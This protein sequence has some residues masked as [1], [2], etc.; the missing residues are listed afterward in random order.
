MN[1]IPVVFVTTPVKD[2]MVSL[3]INLIEPKAYAKLRQLASA[4]DLAFSMTLDQEVR[5]HFQLQ[6]LGET[7]A[8]FTS[9]SRNTDN[10][11]E[12]RNHIQ[13]AMNSVTY[14]ETVLAYVRGASETKNIMGEDSLYSLGVANGVLIVGVEHGFFKCLEN[15]VSVKKFYRN[16]LELCQSTIPAADL[17]QSD[18]F[19]KFVKLSISF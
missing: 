19:S 16:C 7:P 2:A 6:E 8:L 4:S 17:H 9:L 11:D 1:S 18:L 3:N 13:P 12:I 10:Q 5:G 14:K 15:K